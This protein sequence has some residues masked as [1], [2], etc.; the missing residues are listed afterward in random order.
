M[1]AERTVRLEQTIGAD[2]LAAVRAENRQLIQQVAGI[3][4]PKLSQLL[5]FLPV[6]FR[7]VWGEVA[8]IG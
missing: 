3:D 7:N 6:I 2:E 1:L 4:A 8:V 5:E